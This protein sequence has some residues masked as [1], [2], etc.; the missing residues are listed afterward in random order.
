MSQKT[1]YELEVEDLAKM[2]PAM[3]EYQIQEA[4]MLGV[5]N[6]E[7]A[8]NAVASAIEIVELRNKLQKAYGLKNKA[9][10]W[11]KTCRAVL[12]GLCATNLYTVE[13]TAERA[14]KIANEMHGNLE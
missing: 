10:E 13:E 14:K 1:F 8:K 5:T 2:D 7:I 6:T 9:E 12:T 4:L 3:V 11:W